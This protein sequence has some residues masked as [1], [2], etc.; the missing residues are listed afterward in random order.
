MSDP[1]Q[2]ATGADPQTLAFVEDFALAM[3]R[4]GLVRMT[5][6]VMAWLLVCDPPAQTF[7]QIA[8]ALQASKGSISTA[9]KFLTTAGWVGKTSKP[10]VRGDFYTI[11]SGAMADLI[12]QQSGQ[13]AVF[14]Q[15]TA[16][17]LALFEDAPPERSER[18]RDMHEF[19]SWLA[20]ELPALMDRW[21]T[22]RA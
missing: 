2:A 17:G 19:F 7:G 13:Y 1:D 8:E 10:G 16:R 4:L 20:K 18:L 21:E 9:L 14:T 15:V 3:E 11:R 5:G 12:K 22:E 6:R